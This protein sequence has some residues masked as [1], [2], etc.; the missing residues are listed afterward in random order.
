MSIPSSSAFV[1]G[2]A[3]QLALESLPFDLAPLW[4]V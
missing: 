4:G 1:A 3:E 2:D